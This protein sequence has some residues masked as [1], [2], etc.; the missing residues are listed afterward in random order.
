MTLTPKHVAQ[1]LLDEIGAA[2]EEYIDAGELSI[3]VDEEGD[4]P[5]ELVALLERITERLNALVQE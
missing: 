4:T 1:I 3:F 5:P 2:D